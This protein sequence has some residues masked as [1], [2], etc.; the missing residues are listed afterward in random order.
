MHRIYEGNTDEHRTGTATSGLVQN[1]FLLNKFI[2]T[3]EQTQVIANKRPDFSIEKL[4]DDNL[5]PHLFIEVKSLINSNFN[6]IMDQLYDTVLN[7][8]DSEGGNFS[9]YLIAMKGSKIALFQFYYFV[10][11]LDEY[12]V[13]N[14][15]GF[16]PL[17]YQIPFEIYCSINKIS[18]EDDYLAYMIKYSSLRGSDTLVGV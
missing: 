11:L 18:N 16:V 7:T 1:Y 3:P 15:K 14:Y 6:N 5:V 8:V 13:M 17:N 10:S 9:V 2:T 4:V 12:G